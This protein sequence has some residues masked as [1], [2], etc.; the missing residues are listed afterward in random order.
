M[1][2]LPWKEI[3]ASSSIAG[4]GH[5]R[6]ERRTI[7]ATEVAA[8]LGFPHATQ[9]LQVRR[10]VT[11]NGRK[12][13]EV[14]YP[15]TSMPMTEA[16]PLQVAAWIRGHWAMGNQ[17]Y[18]VR[19]ATFDEDRS[20]TRTGTGRRTWPPSATRP[21]V[22]SGSPASRTSPLGYG[23]TVA[24]RTAR[25]ICFTPYDMGL[26]DFAGDPTFQRTTVR[27]RAVDCLRPARLLIP[28]ASPPAQPVGRRSARG[29]HVAAPCSPAQAPAHRSPRPRRPGTGPSS[30]QRSPGRAD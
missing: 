15:I 20:T 24:T 1:K 19:D 4:C 30:P 23:I 2:A 11:R 28:R 22:S 18:W 16:V 8:G 17:L 29:P 3:P 10:T 26:R 27:T 5:G 21:S 14:V 9:V 13:V 6:R 7:K 25:S 12:A